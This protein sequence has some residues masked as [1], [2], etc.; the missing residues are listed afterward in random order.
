MKMIMAIVNSDD[1]NAVVQNLMNAHFSVT[2]L[3][4]S[5]GFLRSGNVTILVGVE[6]EKVQEVIDIIHKYSHSRK[7]MIPTA[8]EAGM[9]F[10]PSMPVEI[11]VGGATIF[12]LDVSRFEK[13]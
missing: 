1:A 5:G 13:F 11:L 6:D 10:Y 12:V 4:S 3:A 2:R 7:Q 9:N 8:A